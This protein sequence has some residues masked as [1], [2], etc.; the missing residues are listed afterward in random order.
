MR[1][2]SKILGGH[3]RELFVNKGDA[4]LNKGQLNSKQ[5]DDV[6]VNKG[7]EIS[8]TSNLIDRQQI[9]IMLVSKVEPKPLV[10]L[11]IAVHDP[12]KLAICYL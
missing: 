5:K 7:A 10:S 3:I 1:P 9:L 2:S 12:S 6:V 11:R 4:C 8:F